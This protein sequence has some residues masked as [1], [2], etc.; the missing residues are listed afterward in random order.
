MKVKEAFFLA[1]LT[2][3]A[4]LV[5]GYHPYMDDAAFYVPAVKKAIDPT[6]Y[7]RSAEFFESHARLTLFPNL[8][9]RIARLLHLPLDYVLLLL[10]AACMFL[11]VF[12]C[13][14]LGCVCFELPEARWCAAAVVAATLTVPV[15]GTALFLFDSCL[16]P[17]CFSA[18][19][20][21]FAVAAALGRRYAVAA[22]WL[23]GAALIHPLM[24]VYGA[25]FILL[26]VWNRAR[27]NG[28]AVVAGT[29]APSM[30]PAVLA[31]Q[32]I[33]FDPPTEAYHQAAL[34]HDFHYVV[35]W[36]WYEWIGIFAPVALFL[37]F[38]RIARSR[39]LENVALLCRTLVPYVLLSF[40]AAL[41]LDIPARFEALARFQP[42]RSLYL[43]YVV[44][45]VLVGGMLGQ[46]VLKRSVGRWLLLFV[47]LCAGLSAYQAYSFP[48]TP[49]YEWPW[50]ANPNQWV[51]AFNWIRQNTPRDAYFALD[52]LHMELPGEDVHGFRAIAERGMLADI[53]KDSGA[54]SMFPGL[55]G[56]WW[57][58]VSAQKD[59]RKFQAADFTRLRSS[60]G[61]DW[62]VLQQ[63]G[64]AGMSCPYENAAVRVCRVN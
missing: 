7:P 11:F 32:R 52:P 55:A 14:K 58:Q 23:A 39:R 46:F 10:Q 42:M 25:F 62:A 59:W 15:A 6:L 34:R 57:E 28:Q 20:A 36:E 48:A 33:S 12:A 50:S 22:A 41:V 1:L 18:F 24:P 56:A 38:Y 26:L 61:V 54:V 17:R 47:P 51:Q 63:P 13:W 9:A 43:A 45:F 53:V 40:A 35:K 8:V 31:P 64:V 49:Y 4:F 30:A 21:V 3:G 2:A 5:R 19:A 29:P 37:W 60:Y 44:M 16:N 27:E